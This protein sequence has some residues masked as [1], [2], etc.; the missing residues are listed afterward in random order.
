LFLLIGLYKPWAVLWWEDTQNRKKVIRIY[1]AL[2]LLFF[3]TYYT[4]KFLV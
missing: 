1:G 2:T 4:L 3:I